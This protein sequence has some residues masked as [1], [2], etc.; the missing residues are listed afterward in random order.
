MCLVILGDEGRCS[1]GF[2]L[3]VWWQN[4][5]CLVVP[6]QSVD[7]RFD[8]NKTELGIAVLAVTLQVLA[9]AHGLLDLKQS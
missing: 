9:D 1:A 4:S 3:P 7:T 2:V 8:E 6:C 5:A